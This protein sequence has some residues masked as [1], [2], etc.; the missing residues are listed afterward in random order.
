MQQVP[1]PTG[2]PVR[3]DRIESM[4]RLP[5]PGEDNSVPPGSAHFIVD[6]GL[7]VAGRRLAQNVTALLGRPHASRK[8]LVRRARAIA[9]VPLTFG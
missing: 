7:R 5:P 8:V 1:T 4:R 9:N 6:D 3:T 2:T